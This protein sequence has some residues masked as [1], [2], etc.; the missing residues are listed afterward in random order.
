M[1][2]QKAEVKLDHTFTAQAYSST[3]QSIYRGSYTG[4]ADLPAAKGWAVVGSGTVVGKFASVISPSGAI[5][6][7][8]STNSGGLNTNYVDGDFQGWSLILGSYSSSSF[9][10][11]VYQIMP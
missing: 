8:Q 10:G 7:S 3:F 6:S 5:V 1:P 4:Y 2:T 9:S 11:S